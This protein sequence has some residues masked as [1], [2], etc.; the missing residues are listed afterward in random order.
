MIVTIEE[1]HD[2]IDDN[3]PLYNY[4]ID[5]QDCDHLYHYPGEAMGKATNPNPYRLFGIVFL[6]Y[7]SQEK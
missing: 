2:P 3:N 4:I 5:N 1:Y 7:P 6:E